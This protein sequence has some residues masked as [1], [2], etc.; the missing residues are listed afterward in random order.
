MIVRR[1]LE[2]SLTLLQVAQGRQPADVYIRGGRVVDVYSGEILEANLALKGDRIA[3]LG[4]SESMVGPD[5]EVVDA[6]GYYLAPGYIDPHF[7]LDTYY[8]PHTL[9]QEVITRGTTAIFSNSSYP[10]RMFPT[11]DFHR[12]IQELR[13]LPVKIFS[14][15][16][17]QKYPFPGDPEGFT[18]EELE[19]LFS[20][21]AVFGFNEV[22]IWTRILERD[23]TLLRKILLA[24]A[25]GKR[26]D[27]HTAGCS[28]D[29]LNIMVAAGLTSCHESLKAEEV[30][31]RV[32]VGLYTMLRHSS[33]RPDLERVL[34]AVTRHRVST[35][36]L[37]FNCDGLTPPDLAER[38]HIDY[39]VKTA[40]A[41]GVEPVTAFQMAS[42]N[43]ATYHG[44][45]ADLGGL[46]PGRYADIL[47]LRDLAS[48][49]PELVM[50]NGV[51]VAREGELLVGFPSPLY[52]NYMRNRHAQPARLERV[53][54][55]MFLV[56]AE[57]REV[58]WPVMQIVN[59]V[60]NRRVEWTLQVRGGQVQCD[61][62]RD[63]LKVA[64]VDR[65]GGKVT[66]SFLSGFGARVGGMASTE[67]AAYQVIV[68]GQS[69]VD[70]AQAV[71]RA[72]DLK[73]GVVVV[74]GGQV[75][76]ELA[77]PLGGTMSVEP[78]RTLATK[79]KAMNQYLAEIGCKMGDPYYFFSF[80][81]STFF[82][83]LRLTTQGLVDVKSWELL[84][85]ARQVA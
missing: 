42:L 38:G 52:Y 18:W 5:T 28:Y 82:P 12:F 34:P 14:G 56:P 83:Q 69:E 71:N 72:L 3:Y 21:E 63:L 24:K 55:H 35:S 27:G 58:S 47:F 4:G 26:V 32:R 75:F 2:E 8:N 11:Q 30:L 62:E 70:M 13:R 44:L 10:P 45:D 33:S 43:P 37:M 29:R 77:L 67:N 49:R 6:T 40:I 76:H 66:T 23:E 65:Q 54:P 84:V 53:S 25:K 59:P 19:G 51:L 36:R 60:V 80:L 20:E 41:M 7:H 85:P 15:V 64:L 31:D 57:G 81:P 74:Q 79:V 17:E 16:P 1:S 39:L 48:G 78:V 68:V 9:A 73:G 50:A 22:G 46:A 61:P